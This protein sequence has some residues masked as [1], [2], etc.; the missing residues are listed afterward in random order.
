VYSCR[1]QRLDQVGDPPD[2]VN[3]PAQEKISEKNGSTDHYGTQ[4]H[5]E[6]GFQVDHISDPQVIHGS[7]NDP[8]DQFSD[9]VQDISEEQLAQL[10]EDGGHD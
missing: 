2:Q 6:Q 5:T 8:M 9:P 7:R 1:L 4:R 10:L 3:D